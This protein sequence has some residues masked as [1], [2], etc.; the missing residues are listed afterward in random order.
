M[1]RLHAAQERVDHPTY[2]LTASVNGLF[3]KDVVVPR[4][5]SRASDDRT[6]VVN[7]VVVHRSPWQRDLFKLK[8]LR[9]LGFDRGR[10]LTLNALQN[11]TL[12]LGV[13][14]LDPLLVATEA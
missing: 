3:W 11:W 2:D 5:D 10:P 7:D 12:L 6:T 4:V 9:P 8:G 1:V 14:L 13:R